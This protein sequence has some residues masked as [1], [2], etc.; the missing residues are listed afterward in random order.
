[1]KKIL[2][3]MTVCAGLL[4]LAACGAPASQ[5]GGG[6]VTGKVWALTTLNGQ[7]PVDG[8]GISAQFTADGKVSGSAGCNQYSG[9]YTV[10]GSNITFDPSIA[11]T[12][13]ACSQPIMDQES[14]YLKMLGEAKTY[15]VKGDELTLTGA[16]NTKLATYK[17]Q[18]QDLSWNQLGSNWI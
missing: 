18:T 8:R 6:D 16:N 15:T 5:D 9:K 10:S 14:A 1:M 11:T 4:T 17:A 13:M 7:P 3:S 2:F 12:M